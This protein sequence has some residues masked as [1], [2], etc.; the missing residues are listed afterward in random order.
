MARVAGMLEA[1]PA[2]VK[3]ITEWVQAVVAA[4]QMTFKNRDEDQLKPYLRPGVPALSL[5]ARPTVRK[6]PLDLAGWRYGNSPLIKSLKKLPPEWK[7]ITVAVAL[8]SSSL[9]KSLANW[10]PKTHNLTI[11]VRVKQDIPR[12]EDDIRHELQHVT[13][14]FMDSLAGLDNSVTPRPGMPSRQIMTPQHSQALQLYD[15]RKTYA[16]NYV[17]DD[18]EFYPQ[19]NDMIREAQ[20]HLKTV[21]AERDQKSYLLK[22]LDGAV[23]PQMEIWKRLAKG[24]W[25]KAVTEFYRTFPVLANNHMA[26]RVASRWL[27]QVAP[28]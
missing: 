12:L 2:M 18:M 26:S 28:D 11:K 20:K 7:T 24:K 23:F 3:D 5:G 1:P 19:L 22:V 14:S 16:E 6:F 27:R 15:E 13:Q 10:D 4:L 21:D 9:E 17:L 8:A 25:K